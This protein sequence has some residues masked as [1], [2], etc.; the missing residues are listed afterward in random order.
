MV[1]S[2]QMNNQELGSLEQL[3]GLVSQFMIFTDVAIPGVFLGQSLRL[4]KTLQQLRHT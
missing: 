2:L 4:R 1:E 3:H